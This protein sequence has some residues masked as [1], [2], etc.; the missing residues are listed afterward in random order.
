MTTEQLPGLQLAVKLLA[1]IGDVDS[2]RA[3]AAVHAAAD[4][5]DD[6]RARLAEIE[7][8]EP[9]LWSYTTD[10][11]AKGVRHYTER[12][13]VAMTSCKPGSLTPFYASPVPAQAVPDERA[14]RTGFRSYDGSG[15]AATATP[16][17]IWRDAVKWAG[18][19]ST[20]PEHKA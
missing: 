12:R 9:V 1:Q 17:Q 6:L 11:P 16:W 10:G 5:R 13:A 19:H 4:E 8:Q 14:V 7:E 18:G 15:W 3:I 20:A 2:D